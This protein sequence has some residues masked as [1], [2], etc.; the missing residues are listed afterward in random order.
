M[1][2]YEY[3]AIKKNGKSKGGKIDAT[4]LKQAISTLQS[5]GLYLTSI[6]TAKGGGQTSST[7]GKRKKRSSVSSKTITNFTRQFSVLVSTGIPYDK[8][9]EILIEEGDDPS[10]QH[11]ISEIKGHI[12]EGSS[13]AGALT[14]FE[15]LFSGMY[16]AMV[17]AGEAGGTL[18]R[19]LGQLAK[20]REEEEALKAK[21]QSAMIYPLIMTVM[22]IGI[23]IFMITFILPKI[24]P[25]F[26]QF[27]VALPF[28][29][30]VVMVISDLVVNQWYLIIA[31]L[32]GS[33][34][35]MNRFIATP[36]GRR[37]WDKMLLNLPVLGNV[38]TKVAAFRFT[39]T[40]G[41]L[42]ESGVEVKHSLDIVKKVL[43]NKVFED[44]FENVSLEITHK[45][46]DLSHALKK[47]GIFPATVIQMIRVGEESSQLHGMLERVSVTLEKEVKQIIEKS[48]A[49]L[50]PVMILWMAVMV[51]FIV[52]A[53]MLPMFELNQ[54]I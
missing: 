12:V 2:I 46:V 41:T 31:L 22:G 26:Q 43:G 5:Q 52:L 14:Q 29:T 11:I 24:T 54:L 34:F 9:L 19:V 40:L 27:N 42:L 50:E 38:I 44:K 35:L 6:T 36:V 16:I 21:I 45:G 49:L 51:G 1:P 33:W 10:F 37:F 28:P 48:V 7:K 18:D 53:V 32:F 20:V 13:L 17:R 3:R 4:T 23:V 8:A 47:T 25:I 30:R 39:Q 15:N